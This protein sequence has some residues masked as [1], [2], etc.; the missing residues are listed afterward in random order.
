M[1]SSLKR[2][3]LALLIVAGMARSAHADNV[4]KCVD[5]SERGQK[6]QRA[7]KLSDAKAAFL[8]CAAEKCPG[9][10]KQACAGWL[11]D[12]NAA[13]PSIVVAVT[14]ADHHDIVAAKVTVDGKPAALGH[15]V[16]LDPGSHTVAVE[17]DGYDSNGDSLVARENEKGRTITIVL[18]KHVDK[19]PAPPPPP[20]HDESHGREIR[21]IT[22]FTGGL[23]VAGLASFTTFAILGRTQADNLRATCAPF[24]ADSDRS[25]AHTKY[26]IADIS[27][28]AA[29]VLAGVS[30]YTYLTGPER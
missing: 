1:V 14:D 21:P 3:G 12:V 4:Q 8:E 15:A 11:D 30:V 17:A 25:S 13:L 6:A 24:C 18:T 23:A 27:L 29:I 20:V 16:Q 19:V 22:W 26:L 5:A 7:G 2:T 28:V 9:V 10:V